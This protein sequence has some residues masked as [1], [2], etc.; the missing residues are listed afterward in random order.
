MFKEQ[1]ANVLK[2]AVIVSLATGCTS[3]NI[4]NNKIKEGVVDAVFTVA[5]YNATD[6]DTKISKYL[7]NKVKNGYIT[8]EDRK[9]IEICIKRYYKAKK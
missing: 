4:I 7:D 1:I 3:S 8:I 9:I 5:E 6:R 2:I